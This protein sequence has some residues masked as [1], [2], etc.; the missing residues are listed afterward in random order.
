MKCSTSKN[1]RGTL[2]RSLSSR[3]IKEIYVSTSNL[4]L[5][6]E[7]IKN[8]SHSFD[9]RSSIDNGQRE[10]ENYHCLKTIVQTLAICLAPRDSCYLLRACAEHTL[11]SE[12][13]WKQVRKG[14]KVG[15]SVKLVTRL[16]RRKR[17][18]LI[19]R[20]MGGTVKFSAGLNFA[21]YRI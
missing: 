5:Q 7:I 17:K 4:T 19:Q 20:K 15:D 10:K 13:L 9:N 1:K 18:H 14:P 12:Q 21:Y 16:R 2:R 11:P 8:I 6:Y 3:F